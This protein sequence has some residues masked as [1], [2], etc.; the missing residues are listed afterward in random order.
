MRKNFNYCKSDTRSHL[1]KRILVQNRGGAAFSPL[2]GTSHPILSLLRVKTGRILPYFED[3]KRGTNP[4][5]KG[6]RSKD[7]F[8]IA[9]VKPMLIGQQ[10]PK[11]RI[12]CDERNAK[13]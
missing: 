7:F 5:E 4:A 8:E 11:G 6:G 12:C 2:R 1:K 13:Y 10:S 9:S 3:L